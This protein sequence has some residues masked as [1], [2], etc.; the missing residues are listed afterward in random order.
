VRRQEHPAVFRR[1]NLS[2]ENYLVAMYHLAVV[3]WAKGAGRD[4]LQ[5]LTA[6]VDGISERTARQRMSRTPESTAGSALGDG[7]ADGAGRPSGPSDEVGISE[8]RR[9]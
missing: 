1:T 9:R 5:A 2:E 7:A 3:L 6:L 4:A 8:R